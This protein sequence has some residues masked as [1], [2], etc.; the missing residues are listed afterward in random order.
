MPHYGRP[1][2]GNEESSAAMRVLPRL[3]FPVQL[4]RTPRSACAC[5]PRE[6]LPASAPSSKRRLL[7]AHDFAATV[8]AASPSS[9]LHACLY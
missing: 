2:C 5:M 3:L 7:L 9:L 8:V 1:Q 4:P 6:A